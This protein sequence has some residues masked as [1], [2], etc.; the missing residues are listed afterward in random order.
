MLIADP[1]IGALKNASYSRQRDILLYRMVEFCV[2]HAPSSLYLLMNTPSAPVS[3]ILAR[4]RS[5]LDGERAQKEND[6]K[7]K[8]KKTRRESEKTEKT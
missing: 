4:G 6:T 8:R 3:L 2:E 1:T 5:Q 7:A